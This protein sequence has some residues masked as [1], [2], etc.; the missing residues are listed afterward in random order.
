M[1][2]QRRPGPAQLAS[3]TVLPTCVVVPTWHQHAHRSCAGTEDDVPPL[4]NP[5]AVS[6]WRGP[7][8]VTGIN[9]QPR[10]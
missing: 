7:N 2:Q 6:R 1:A 8:I 3:T 10:G 5:V 4:Q 9:R